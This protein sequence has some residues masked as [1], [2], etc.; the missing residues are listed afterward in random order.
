MAEGFTTTRWRSRGGAAL[1]LAA[2]LVSSAPAT[3]ARAQDGTQTPTEVFKEIESV[4]RDLVRHV[5]ESHRNPSVENFA[6]VRSTA[7]RLS[8]LL[9]SLGKYLAA[10]RDSEDAPLLR[11]RINDLREFEK[12][13]SL[14]DSRDLFITSEVDTRARIVYKP[15]PGFTEEARRANVTGRV[16]LLAVLTPDGSVRHVVP[17]ESL[18]YGMTEK[19]IEAARKIRFE[20]AMKGGRV[21]SQVI[22]LEY[23]FN[24]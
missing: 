11:E 1:A 17:L 21:V 2:V 24:I 5:S 6:S 14:P 23:N 3:N 4:L 15:E 18:G 20:P 7:A 22:I 10:H 16:R 12:L 9:D 13:A 19:A 8:G